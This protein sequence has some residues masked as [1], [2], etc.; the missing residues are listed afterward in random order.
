[1]SKA[2]WPEGIYAIIIAKHLPQRDAYLCELFRQYKPT[3]DKVEMFQFPS[4]TLV[5]IE[6]GIIRPP[7]SFFSK[8]TQAAEHL[9]ERIVCMDTSTKY[10]TILLYVGS[11]VNELRQT[12]LMLRNDFL[13]DQLTAALTTS[14]PGGGSISYWPTLVNY[15]EGAIQ[16][17]VKAGQYKIVRRNVDE[18]HYWLTQGRAA[19]TVKCTLVLVHFNTALPTRTVWK[20]LDD[21]SL[22][23]GDAAELLALG[24]Q[25]PYLQFNRRIVALDTTREFLD[26]VHHF[27]G[28][29]CM[30]LDHDYNCRMLNL[31]T[32]PKEWDEEW[33]FL[34]I[35]K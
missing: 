35:E 10:D 21:L 5:K 30:Y 16:A 18:S 8:I 17:L 15:Q 32:L 25:H 33:H 1:M 23:P 9:L 27:H 11:T 19:G 4:E 24:A 2:T 14:L 13:E 7:S 26:D 12:G 20:K 34:A 28:A 22:K 29:G 3:P 31:W 6:N